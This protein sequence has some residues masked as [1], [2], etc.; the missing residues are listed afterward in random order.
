MRVLL[1]NG[2]IYANGPQPLTAMLCADDRI[3]WVGKDHDGHAADRVIDLDGRI[4][5][6][7]FVDAHVHLTSTGLDVVDCAVPDPSLLLT[8]FAPSSAVVVGHGWDDT[9]WPRNWFDI[10]AFEAQVGNTAVYASRVDVHSAFVSRALLRQVPS[11]LDGWSVTGILTRA[12]HAHARTLAF[13]ALTDEQRRTAQQRA[14]RIAAERGIAGLQEMSGPAIASARDAQLL[15]DQA[16]VHS[17]A[18]AI[19]W[20][21]LHGIHTARELGAYGVGG[22]LVIDGSVGS[23]TAAFHEPYFDGPGKGE[24]YQDLDELIAHITEALHAG[25]PNSFH[26]IGDAAISQVIEAYSQVARTIPLD[27]IRG[28]RH[29]IEHCELIRDTDL[30]QL[31]EF[32]IVASMQPA[33]DA[34]WGGDGMY[35]Q[36]LGVERAARMNRFATMARA[37]VQLAFG[38]DAPVTA[39]D[40]WAGVHAAQFHRTQ[41]ESLTQRGAIAAHTRGGWRSIG[42]DDAGMLTEGW[43]ATYA[44]WE[45]TGNVV[46]AP[47][48]RISRWSTDPRAGIP[49]LPDMRQARCVLTVRRG[50]T[51]FD[52][53]S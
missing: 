7:A 48:E 41:E 16:S 30:Q 34:H 27:R 14:L 6:P 8:R 1:R 52:A 25:L 32:G 50:E 5:V 51:L 49:Q 2:V 33:F 37:G 19:W 36:R 11:D 13:A 31:A 28:A 4:V 44:V 47:D 22:D 26:A 10:D 46:A 21:E 18:V 35:R 15:R 43:E 12:A 20:G 3:V 38:S 9:D 29:R 42:V 40:P 23:R 45:G 53:L 24:L 39:L 17:P